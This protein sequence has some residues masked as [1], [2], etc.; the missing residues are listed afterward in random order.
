MG[1]EILED[2]KLLYYGRYID[3]TLLIFDEKITSNSVDLILEKFNSLHR[4]IKFTAEIK[5][6]SGNLPFLDMQLYFD[7]NSNLCS[8]WYIKPQHSENF[9]R[10]DEFI[11]ENIKRNTIIERFRAVMVRSTEEQYAREGIN[12]LV[13]ILS[14]NNHPIFKIMGAIRQAYKKNS[15][16]LVT[17]ASETVEQPIYNFN[18]KDTKQ[19]NFNSSTKE[20]EPIKSIL[21]IPYISE[22]LKSTI[23]SVIEKFGRGDDIRVVYTSNQRVKFLKPSDNNQAQFE[24]RDGCPICVGIEGGDKYHCGTRVVVYKIQCRICQEFYIGKTNKTL[25]ERIT[26]HFNAYKNKTTNSP[27]WSHESYFHGGALINNWETFFEKYRVIVIRQNSDYVLNN[28]DEAE[29]ITKLKP[30]LNRREEVPE[31]DIVE[32]AIMM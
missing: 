23:N 31:W 12:R 28:I 25:K 11:P 32:S 9:I 15:N 10:G 4:N 30:S 14:K 6:S 21:K 24:V 26:Q 20:F 7:V 5:D 27:L 3:D 17:N 16:S 2:T 18:W 13:K 8:K 19:D 22:N 1:G 29:H